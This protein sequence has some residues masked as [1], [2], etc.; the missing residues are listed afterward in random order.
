[1]VVSSVAVDVSRGGEGQE[2]PP[3]WVGLVAFGRVAETLLKQKHGDLIS[4]S[5]RVQMNRWEDKE[6]NS[7]E[8][9]QV[10]A[11]SII[12]ARA[13]RP[14]GG[15]RSGASRASAGNQGMQG[16]GEYDQL[17]PHGQPFNDDLPM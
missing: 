9:L 8:Q 13:I 17:A 11:D 10:I 4:A 7:R 3:L 2:P 12:S 14:G 1:M 6:G 5:G 16:C 15:R